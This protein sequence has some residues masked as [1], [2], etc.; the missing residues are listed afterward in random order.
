M[1]LWRPV[2]SDAWSADAG[3]IL[4]G[5][6]GLVSPLEGPQTRFVLWPATFHGIKPL[7]MAWTFILGQI[8]FGPFALRSH[9]PV[10]RTA[11]LSPQ[12]KLGLQAQTI[13]LGLNRPIIE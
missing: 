12:K 7:L 9:S 3:L 8:F 5:L 4:A 10:G 11:A 6:K 1:S 2:K 13:S